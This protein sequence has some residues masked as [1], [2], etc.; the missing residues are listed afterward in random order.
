MVEL[1]HRPAKL[2]AILL[3]GI[4]QIW[5]KQC[6]GPQQSNDRGKPV[7]DYWRHRAIPNVV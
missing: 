2:N 7:H 4:C 6:G 5:D 3:D 1:S